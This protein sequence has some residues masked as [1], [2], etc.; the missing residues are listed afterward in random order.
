MSTDNNNTGLPKFRIK[1]VN[2]ENNNNN[3]NNNNNTLNT[4]KKFYK[5]NKSSSV[6]RLP[7]LQ[8]I[9]KDFEIAKKVNLKQDLGRMLS[10]EHPKEPTIDEKVQFWIQKKDQMKKILY[11]NTLAKFATLTRPN[12]TRGGILADDMGLDKMIQMIALIAFKPAINLDSTY[13]KTT[14]IHQEIL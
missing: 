3:N 6:V 7:K 11:F 12:L 4:L 10:N 14:L 1:R 2:N 13:S 5:N 8:V 9:P